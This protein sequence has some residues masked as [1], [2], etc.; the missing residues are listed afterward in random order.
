MGSQYTQSTII[1]V[2]LADCLESQTISWDS[3][4]FSAEGHKRTMTSFVTL[5]LAACSLITLRLRL[6]LHS[7]HRARLWVMPPARKE[8]WC[9][10]IWSF[11]FPAFPTF[12]FCHAGLDIRTPL[13]PY[14]C[15][16]GLSQF[17][18]EPHRLLPSVL[19]SHLSKYLS[20][21]GYHLY[22][23]LRK[24]EFLYLLK[25]LCIWV[26]PPTF[27]DIWTS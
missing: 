13:L 24:L 1:Y 15:Y 22:H 9:F 7:S 3:S 12:H 26:V 19:C 10:I 23:V 16:S 2:L 11:F 8:T 27:I 20:K 6:A 25:P 17:F 4:W 18:P 21:A 5:D 14:H